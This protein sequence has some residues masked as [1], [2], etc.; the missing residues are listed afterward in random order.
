MLFFLFVN[1]YLIRPIV[2]IVSQDNI[3]GLFEEKQGT[4]RTHSIYYKYIAI[5]PYM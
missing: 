3:L 4:K 1:V 5:I 2:A